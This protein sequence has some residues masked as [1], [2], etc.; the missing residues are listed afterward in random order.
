MTL[1]QNHRPS[2][3]A[4]KARHLFQSGIHV[5]IVQLAGNGLLQVIACGLIRVRR[6]RVKVDAY[7]LRQDWRFSRSFAE[8]RGRERSH[9]LVGLM[10]KRSF[11]LNALNDRKIHYLIELHGSAD[12]SQFSIHVSRILPCALK[13]RRVGRIEEKLN[14][15]RQICRM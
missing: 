15:F 7:G 10:S 6:I 3:L 9:A 12:S 4:G 8:T 13:I 14:I 1:N 2:K 5:R 11:L